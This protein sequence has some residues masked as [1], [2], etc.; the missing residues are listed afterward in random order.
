MS[1][2]HQGI[3]GLLLR[4]QDKIVIALSFFK[5]GIKWRWFSY[6]DD[7]CNSDQILEKNGVN[8]LTPKNC[9]HIHSCFSSVCSFCFFFC[10]L[11]AFSFPLSMRLCGFSYSPYV[12]C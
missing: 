10:F 9:C 3:S 2:R 12:V 5:Y 7:D 8:P 11:K 6:H 4:F 1:A